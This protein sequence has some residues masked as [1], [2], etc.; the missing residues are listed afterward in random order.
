MHSTQKPFENIPI[1]IQNAL[2]SD[3]FA[4]YNQSLQTEYLYRTS[5]GT[6]FIEPTSGF[7]FQKLRSLRKSLPYDYDSKIAFAKN[8]LWLT[9]L[10]KKNWIKRN[11]VISLRDVYEN[12]YF[13]F[14]NDILTK[15]P[16]INTYCGAN[17]YPIV[18]SE[19]LSKK[20]FFGEVYDRNVFNDREVIVQDKNTFVS[21]T[22]VI[23][24]KPL[25]HC[26]HYLDYI[27][28]KLGV[29]KDPEGTRRT[30]V[31]RN[32]QTEHGRTLINLDEI[33]R[34]CEKYDFEMVDPGGMSLERQIETYS[35]SLYVVG[36]H[37]G[38]MANIIF[39]RNSKMKVLE[40]FPPDN[41]PPHYY[42][43]SHLYGYDYDAIVGI[44]DK[45]LE[46]REPF[47]LEPN[48]LEK[49]LVELDRRF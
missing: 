20:R 5:V 3:S 18:I 29:Q 27:L 6:Y 43:L 9:G 45:S 46:I 39:R 48:L 17:N 32:R 42:W 37:G 47:Y 40:I 21:A 10:K 15:L 30:F 11:T 36:I 34:L 26:K 31:V 2:I 4:K 1:N 13:H 7:V 28:D 33:K 16:L 22:E 44:K 35:Q 41:I 12:S 14:Y 8:L 23:F 25:P 19:S 24:G 38:G 49:K